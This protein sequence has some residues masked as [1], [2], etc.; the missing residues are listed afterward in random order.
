MAEQVEK[1][2]RPEGQGQVPKAT[3]R[4]EECADITDVTQL[5]QSTPWRV[6]SHTFKIQ[7][8]VYTG[9]RICTS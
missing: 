1:A 7:Q 6:C 2:R 3:Q 8:K 4:Q 5:P 9:K